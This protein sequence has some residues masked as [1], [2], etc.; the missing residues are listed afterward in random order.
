M[1]LRSLR[2]NLRIGP[3]HH[4]I[5]AMSKQMVNLCNALVCNGFPL[6]IAGVIAVIVIAVIVIAVIV[7]AVIVIAVIV[8]AVPVIALSHSRYQHLTLSVQ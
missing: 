5:T 7:I 8:I 6:V 2:L 1:L 3:N 4:R